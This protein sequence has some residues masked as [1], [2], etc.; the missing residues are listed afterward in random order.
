M[1]KRPTPP[2]R[3][4]IAED[5]SLIRAGLRCLLSHEEGLEVV[6]AVAN[7]VE[8]LQQLDQTRP[9]LLLLDLDLPELYW[10]MVFGHLATHG[11][12]TKV[13][14]RTS[15]GGRRAAPAGP[16]GRGQGGPRQAGDSGRAGQGDP[17]G[18]GRGDLD[19]T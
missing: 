2:L 16:P 5:V 11:P 10:R 18:G 14:M 3:V 8:V 19:L 12:A 4:L 13:L 1:A 15:T 7:G 6:G 9:D 17:A